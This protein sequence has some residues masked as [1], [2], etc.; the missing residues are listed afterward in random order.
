MVIIGGAAMAGVGLILLSM[1]DGFLSFCF[2]YVFIVS[3]GYNAGFFHPISAMVNSW[4]IRHRG[5]GLPRWAAASEY[6]RDDHGPGAVLHHPRS[7]LA[8]PRRLFAGLL[9]LA[10]AIPAALPHEGLARGGGARTRTAVRRRMNRSEAASGLRYPIAG[11]RKRS[12]RPGCPEDPA[13]P[14]YCVAC[15]SLR[16]LVT[17]ALNTHFVP[18][19]VWK[20]MSEAASAC[21]GQL[22]CLCIHPPGHRSWD[23]RGIRWNKARLS[24]PVH[25]AGHPGDGRDALLSGRPQSS[26]LFAIAFAFIMGTAPLNWAL[27]R[28]STRTG[29][30]RNPSVGSWESDTASATFLSPVCAGWIFDRTESYEIVL[31]TFSIILTFTAICSPSYP[32]TSAPAKG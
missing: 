28:R 23:G 11:A 27:D 26:I 29:Q 22:V 31:I 20:G 16:L 14:G 24:G 25:R 7:R 9:I 32:P 18:L 19:L 4:F 6:R 1:V 12:H 3:L 13:I 2:V 8:Q 30:L 15:I 10:I 5:L 17:V 21:P